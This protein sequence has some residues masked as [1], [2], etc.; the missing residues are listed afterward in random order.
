MKRD[1]LMLSGFVLLILFISAVSAISVSK[2]CV[3]AQIT[4]EVQKYL[5]KMITRLSVDEM[6]RLLEIYKSPEDSVD[7]DDVSL[8]IPSNAREFLIEKCGSNIGNQ[9]GN[10]TG[11]LTGNNTGGGN[12]TGNNTG[13]QTNNNTIEKVCNSDSDC[14]S[15]LC[16]RDKC[17]P[18][19]ARVCFRDDSCKEG[20]CVKPTRNYISF[21]SFLRQGRCVTVIDILGEGE[22]KVP[23]AQLQ[24]MIGKSGMKKIM[25]AIGRGG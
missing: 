14:D 4:S 12:L 20:V 5:E 23:L 3:K 15:G 17:L 22:Q 9:T 24:K 8:N 2:S 10:S 13:N 7:L 25:A 21:L 6:K 18:E 16:F 19:S 1:Y 11:N